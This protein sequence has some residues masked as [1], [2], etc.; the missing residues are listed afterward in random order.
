MT[1]K[2]VTRTE[3]YLSR[4]AGENFDLP[5]PITRVEKYLYAIATGSKNVP[6]PITRV[7]HYLY[8]IATGSS[9]SPPSPPKPEKKPVIFSPKDADGLMTADGLMFYV[10]QA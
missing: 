2:P 7:E 4:I 10:K 5:P 3:I 8:I 6:E 1:D 9:I